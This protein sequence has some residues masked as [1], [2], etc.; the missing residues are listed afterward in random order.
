MLRQVHAPIRK[1]AVVC[2]VR[3]KI[4]LVEYALV[5]LARVQTQHLR[6]ERLFL[7][8]IHAMLLI[9]VYLMYARHRQ[10][11]QIHQ[12]A[13]ECPGSV[14]VVW[15]GVCWV[16]APPP[17]PEA[18]VYVPAPTLH[19]HAE[20]FQHAL[21]VPCQTRAQTPPSGEFARRLLHATEP[22][23]NVARQAHALH[24]P[25]EPCV[26]EQVVHV[27]TR[28]RLAA[29]FHCAA[30]ACRPIIAFQTRAIRRLLARL[31]PRNV[32]PRAA[33]SIAPWFRR[34]QFAATAG[35]AV[36]RARRARVE[37]LPIPAELSQAVHHATRP[38]RV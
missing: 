16:F 5:E 37:T 2:Q 28:R 29:P 11:A 9:R 15:Q 27:Q 22:T 31:P 7:R 21:T 35:A 19:L 25:M 12:K 38:T 14:K 10:H 33:V 17:Q 3:V 34:S 24:V 30:H 13:V 20:R 6:A 32:V 18:G 8:A 23:Q 4:A 36:P 1:K 26:L